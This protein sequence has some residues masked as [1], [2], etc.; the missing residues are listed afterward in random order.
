MDSKTQALINQLVSL[1]GS[2]ETALVAALLRDAELEEMLFT[3]SG[4]MDKLDLST[5]S[6]VQNVV[7]RVVT[8][9]T[10]LAE[11]RMNGSNLTI[12]QEAMNAITS[13][14]YATFAQQNAEIRQTVV[15]TV[16]RG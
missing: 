13:R 15:E 6:K 11:R 4:I 12:S 14:F 1:Y 5:A 8:Y 9:E 3:I 7:H 10:R 16:N 2:T